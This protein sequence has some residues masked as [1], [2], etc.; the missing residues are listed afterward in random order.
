MKILR[1]KI[2]TSFEKDCAKMHLRSNS[3]RVMSTTSHDDNQDHDYV[4]P[5]TMSPP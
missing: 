3:S 5:M 4:V 2:Q 1:L